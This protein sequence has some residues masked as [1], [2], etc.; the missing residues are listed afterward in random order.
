M[1]NAA[2]CDTSCDLQNP[3]NHQNFERILRFRDM[4]GSMLVGVFVNSTRP[5]PPSRTPQGGRSGERTD[6]ACSGVSNTPSAP[7]RLNSEALDHAQPSS[8]ER[9]VD[10]LL[11]LAHPTRG[12]CRAACVSVWPPPEKTGRC[13]CRPHGRRVAPAQLSFGP[14]IK[15]E[16][17]LNLSI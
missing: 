12:S 7:K 17:P 4:P 6:C 15:Q 16:D 11:R 3:V 2:K 5:D 10:G 14:P 1:K 13:G 9:V 8:A